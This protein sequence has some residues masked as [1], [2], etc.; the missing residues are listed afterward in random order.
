MGD[1]ELVLPNRAASY[2]AAATALVLGLLPLVGNLDWTSTAGIIASIGAI[3]GIAYKWLDN[4]GK[5]ERGEGVGLLPG[6]ELDDELDY[7]E[8]AAAGFDEHTAEPIPPAAVEAANTPDTGPGTTYA[9]DSPRG[10]LERPL[11]RPPDTR[12]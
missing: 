3:L 4:W 2:L 5:Y 9:P 7:D 8:A 6:D 1:S 10:G 11:E 12:P